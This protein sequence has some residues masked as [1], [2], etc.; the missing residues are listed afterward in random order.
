MNR[1]HIITAAP[2]VL[3][4]CAAPVG[5]VC[6]APVEE[7]PIAALFREWQ[8]LEDQILDSDDL[9]D[10]QLTA[11]N[12]RRGDIEF[13]IWAIEATT[14]IDAL[15]KVCAVTVFGVYGEGDFGLK[16][17]WDDARRILGGAA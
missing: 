16:G 12:E 7:T 17:A 15:R 5:A 11:L 8:T 3:L 6:S 9:T 4:G 10:A 13:D 1:R 2:A 14:P